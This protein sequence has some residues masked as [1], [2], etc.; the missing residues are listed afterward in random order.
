MYH[1]LITAVVALGLLAGTGSLAYAEGNNLAE[2]EVAASS[3]VIHAGPAMIVTGSE[4]YPVSSTGAVQVSNTPAMD[5]GGEHYQDL[6]GKRIGGSG[7]GFALRN[8]N[9]ARS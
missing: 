3:S 2:T 1:S 4:M 9:N 7:I 8:G 6:A 5:T